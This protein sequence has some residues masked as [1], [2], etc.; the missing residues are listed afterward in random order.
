MRKT[1]R[2]A[3]PWMF[4]MLVAMLWIV[5]TSFE[6]SRASGKSEGQNKPCLTPSLESAPIASSRGIWH[7]PAPAATSTP[8]GNLLATNSNGVRWPC[9]YNRP[10]LFIRNWQVESGTGPILYEMRVPHARLRI[11][12]SEFALL[13]QSKSEP[14]GYGRYTYALLAKSP[15][16]RERNHRLLVELLEGT[17]Y[18]GTLF[19]VTPSQLNLFEVPV[20]TPVD[21]V[22]TQENLNRF[23]QSTEAHYDYGF[24]RSV[25]DK[26]R[27]DGASRYISLCH[28]SC[29]VGPYLMVWAHP[30]GRNQHLTMPY[31]VVDLSS[32]PDIL[33]PYYVREMKAQ[34]EN[35]DLADTHRIYSMRNSLLNWMVAYSQTAPAIKKAVITLLSQH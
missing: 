17:P 26:V 23:E 12:D 24:A 34:V 28:S 16:Q 14:R 3:L 18:L 11:V 2:V 20:A 5:A 19:G 1:V 8:S 29:D 31:L 25:L 6:C 33:L 13:S 4:A 35:P 22:G 21:A 9:K 7:S 30:V 27:L 32:V 10:D 15:Q